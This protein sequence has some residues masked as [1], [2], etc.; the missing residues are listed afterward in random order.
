[1][2]EKRKMIKI[3]VRPQT[4]GYYVKKTYV[5][6]GR[7]AFGLSVA[8]GTLFSVF[9]LLFGAARAVRARDIFFLFGFGFHLIVARLRFGCCAKYQA[10]LNDF[11]NIAHE[12]WLNGGTISRG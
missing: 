11:V 9:S 5:V 10:R 12:G 2:D 1:M 6:R 4:N 7:H 3:A 8:L